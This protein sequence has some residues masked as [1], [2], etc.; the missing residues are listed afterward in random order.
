[1][2]RARRHRAATP[3]GVSGTQT[4]EE[5]EADAD[6][7]ARVEAIRLQAGPRMSLGDVRESSVPKMLLVSAPCHGG[8]I[9]HLGVLTEAVRDPRQDCSQLRLLT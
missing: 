6:L 7:K 4:R 1:M 9:V 8:V 3:F 5:L 2:W